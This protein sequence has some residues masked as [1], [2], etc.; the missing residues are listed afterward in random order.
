MPHQFARAVIAAALL[1]FAALSI[2]TPSISR[3]AENNL[4]VAT[5]AGGCFWCVE[6][7]FD[8]VR[9][10]ARTISGYYRRRSERSDI[11]TGHRRRHRT[12]GGGADLL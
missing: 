10:V 1:S 2:G 9:G 7:D 5:F 3:A 12:S 8:N 11:Q 4:Q 6:S